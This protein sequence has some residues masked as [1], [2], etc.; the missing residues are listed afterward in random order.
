MRLT[1]I[2]ASLIIVSLLLAPSLCPASTWWEPSADY[3]DLSTIAGSLWQ[4]DVY[5]EFELEP[6][7]T[8]TVSFGTTA[9]PIKG[10]ADAG[11]LMLEAEF[12]GSP[13]PWGTPGETGMVAYARTQPFAQQEYNMSPYSFQALLIEHT[14]NGQM[15]FHFFNFIINGYQEPPE[16]SVTHSWDGYGYYQHLG[17]N[18]DNFTTYEIVGFG[19][20]DQE[21]SL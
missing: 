17:P 21:G 9:Y 5:A 7:A 19:L 20:K 13:R 2:T 1:R 3:Q 12:P 6:M 8:M 18:H 16:R 15:D 10:T 4:F 14:G 11:G